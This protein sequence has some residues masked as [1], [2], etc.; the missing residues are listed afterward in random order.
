VIGGDV[1]SV[2]T[3]LDAVTE[4]LGRDMGFTVEAVTKS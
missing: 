2:E 4:T 1:Q 3:A